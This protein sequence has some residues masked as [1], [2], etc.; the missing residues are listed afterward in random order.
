MQDRAELR[1]FFY[2]AWQKH[3]AN[4]PLDFLE[5]QIVEVILAHPEYHA[6][7]N[8]AEKYQTK[9]FMP[10]AGEINPFLHISLH[11]GL[12]EQISTDRPQGIKAIYTTLCHSMDKHAAEHKMMDCLAEVMWQA[13]RDNVLPDELE[14]LE[15]LQ[16]I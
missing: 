1:E 10:E 6:I 14:Y 9:S 5:Q 8:Q 13:Q 2:T 16:M 12:L 4:Q 15:K 3:Q 11:L 7:F